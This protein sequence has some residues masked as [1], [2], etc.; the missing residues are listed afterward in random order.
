MLS[1][2]SGSAALFIGLLVAQPAS[3]ASCL[4]A[5]QSM[6]EIMNTRHTD[7]TLILAHRGSWGNYNPADKTIPENSIA[8]AETAK[9]YCMDGV[10]LVT[11]SPKLY[12][13]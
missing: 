5:A 2:L 11:C 8:A 1:Y 13:S 7:D 4:T 9:A 6:A 12:Q 3:A 10:E